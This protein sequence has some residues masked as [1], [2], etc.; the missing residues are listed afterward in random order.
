MFPSE[1][2]RPLTKST[3]KSDYGWLGTVRGRR[4]PETILEVPLHLAQVWQDQ[5]F[6]HIPMNGRPPVPPLDGCNRSGGSGMTMKGRM[7]PMNN[8]KPQ[9]VD[10]G[11][12][13]Q[14]LC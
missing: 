8:W 9:T 12:K 2:G 10:F 6:S 3:D 14:E 1:D 5:T 4:R 13:R 11:D 7:G